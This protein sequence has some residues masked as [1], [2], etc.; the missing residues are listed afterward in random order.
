MAVTAGPY[1]FIRHPGYAGMSI[2]MLACVL[3]L[4]SVWAFIPAGLYVVVIIIRT[5]MEDLALSAELPGY[6]EYARKTRFR[7]VPGLW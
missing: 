5:R 7:L 6:S 3:L 2:S 1:R 4:G